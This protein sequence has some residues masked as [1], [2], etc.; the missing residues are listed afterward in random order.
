MRALDA[1]LMTDRFQLG[2]A[3]RSR[4]WEWLIALR[5]RLNVDM[6]L[7][8]DGQTSLLTVSGEGNASIEPVSPAAPGIRMA[9]S[10]AIRTR[11]P[12]AASVDRLQTVIVPI[13]LDRTVTGALI[14]ARRTKED[15]PLERVRSEL[16]AVG[17]WLATAIEAH[18]Q[19]P[20][21]AEGDL[22]R[23][24]ALC[25]LL[26]DASARRSDRDLV[27]VFIE[28]LAVWHDLEGYGYV[29]TTRGEYARDVALPGADPSTTPAVIPRAVLSEAD[30]VSRLT[31]SDADRLGFL[32]GDDVALARVGEG[33]G[34]WLIAV[35]GSMVFEELPRLNLYVA[36]LD[37][38]IAG[39]MQG[40][41]AHLLAALSNDLLTD[42]GR[43]EDQARRVLE[44]LQS[45]LGTTNAAFTVTTRTGTPLLHVGASFTAA[46][47]AGGTDGG[48]IVIV[49]KDPTQYA[50]AL[51][52]AWSPQHHV[53]QQESHVAEAVADLLESWV[54]RLVKQS[55]QAGDRRVGRRGFDE[56]LERMARDAVQGGIPVTAVV[57]SFTDAAFRPDVTQTHVARLREHLR[58][59]DLVGRLGEGDV[60]VLLHDT[61]AAQGDALLARIQ[62]LLQRDGVPLAQVSIGMASRSPGD[63][64]TGTLAQEARRRARYQPSDN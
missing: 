54:R 3:V 47:I 12:Q 22:D 5:K 60:G 30:D 16:E 41:T 32:S 1:P 9:V 23:L 10:T 56:M 14:V 33:P 27:G 34:S 24:S 18:L 43:P 42:S 13:T 49:R 19:S 21:A 2:S 64:M 20:P 7:V 44:H 39:A 15:Q 35:T 26:S 55:P 4:S 17:F 40:A 38:A 48:K 31:R 29:E 36:L 63:P 62:R 58:G 8:D 37:Q 6:Q 50:M 51:V 46:D 45:V 61:V 25:R 53:T 52:G 11:Q 28:T 57:I 59:G